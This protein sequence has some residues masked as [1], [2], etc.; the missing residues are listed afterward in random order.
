MGTMTGKRV[1]VTGATAG[2]GL[3]TARA[4][5]KEGAELLIVGR[6]PEKTKQVVAELTA[7]TGNQAISFL[8]ADLSSMASVKQLA[9]EVLAKFDRLDVLVNNAGAVNPK[10]EVTVDGYELTFATNHLAYFALTL[11]LLPALKKAPSARIVSVASEAHRS[12]AMDF[13]DLMSEPYAAFKAYSR[14][15]LA[16]ILF[17]RELARRLQ[18]STVTANCLHPGVVRS[19]FLAKPGLWGVI[20]KVAGLF[21]ISNVEGAATSIHLATSKEVEGVSGKYFDKSK[22]REPNAA[23]QDD[24]AARR[25]WAE[26]EKLTGVSWPA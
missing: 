7:T 26:S 11:L 16:N 19:N 24:E 18:G 3:E 12:A 13:S 9:A 23:A 6:N 1:V 17:T 10:R 21:M 8:L 15:K 5:A 20:G 25:L 22:P 4:I 14:S 2:I